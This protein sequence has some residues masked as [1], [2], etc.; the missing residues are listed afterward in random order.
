MF[1]RPKEREPVQIARAMVASFLPPSL[2]YTSGWMSQDYCHGAWLAACTRP[3]ASVRHGEDQ[4]ALNPSV[5]GPPCPT[6]NDAPDGPAG[7]RPLYRMR[8]V[9]SRHTDSLRRRPG[10]RSRGVC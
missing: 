3:C 10:G 9:A 7:G 1:T 6:E 5:R 2:P 8:L 4:I